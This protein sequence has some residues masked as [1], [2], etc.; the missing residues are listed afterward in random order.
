MKKERIIAMNILHKRK[1]LC[2]LGL[3]CLIAFSLPL[4]SCS[5]RDQF[6]PPETDAPTGEQ[7]TLVG[8]PDGNDPFESNP[9]ETN[10]HETNQSGGDVTESTTLPETTPTDPNTPK[11]PVGDGSETPKITGNPYEGWTAEELYA[12]F[13]KDDERSLYNNMNQSFGNTPYYIIIDSISGGHMFSKLTGQ[14][15]TIC[16]DPLCTH[17]D[18]IFSNDATGFDGCQVVN[19]RVYIVIRK[20]FTSKYILYSFNLLMDDPQLICEWDTWPQGLYIYKNKAYYTTTIKLENGLHGWGGVVYDLQTKETTQLWKNAESCSYIEYDGEYAWYT[21]NDDGSLRRFNL[22][23]GEHEVILSGELLDHEK[24]E[25]C[26]S[27]ESLSDN[28]LYYWRDEVNYEQ[29]FWQMD[30]TTKIIEE[31]WLPYS[32]KY[33]GAY[34]GTVLHDTDEYVDDPHYA[35][36][37]NGTALA[38]KIYRKNMLNEDLELAVVLRTDGIP[39][40]IGN[41]FVLDGQYIMVEYQT[42]KDFRNHYSST[43]P[44][45]AASKRYIIVNLETGVA[46]ELGVDLSTQ[47]VHKQ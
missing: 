16:K 12:S 11:P 26:F 40:N 19:D 7:T 4:T 32:Y 46:Y 21:Q 2:F 1:K 47:S 37:C 28:T 23:T 5:R 15:V 29:T 35:Y 24:G 43:L 8:Q 27:F 20:V 34:Y 17:D 31:Q 10:P 45:W 38:G 25:L 41:W 44:E 42:Y 18:C 36:Y 9:V 13:R 39:D 33:D 30:L 14:V 22:N 6:R 3:F